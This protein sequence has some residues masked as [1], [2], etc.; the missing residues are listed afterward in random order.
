MFELRTKDERRN[1]K[2]TN[3][4]INPECLLNLIQQHYKH[5][6]ISKSIQPKFPALRNLQINP[7]KWR[8]KPHIE[9]LFLPKIREP[10]T[11]IKIAL[12]WWQNHRFVDQAYPDIARTWWV[13]WRDWENNENLRVKR[14]N[15]EKGAINIKDE[16]IVLLWD[17]K[18]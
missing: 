10:S 17:R 11:K 7:V 4:L 2:D 16:W 9:H 1:G 14:G 8:P 12:K 6:I 18:V 3:K 13:N 5:D 15:R